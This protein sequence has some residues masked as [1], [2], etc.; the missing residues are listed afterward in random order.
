M[1]V[2]LILAGCGQHDGSETH[3]VVLTLLSLAQENIE[4]DSFAPEDNQRQVI[5]H[6]TE[7]KQ[8]GS[9]NILRESARLVRGKIKPMTKADPS[10]YDAI[11][12]PGGF[13]AVSNLCNWSEKGKDFSFHP[14]VGNFF[15]LA[16]SHKKPMGFICIAPMMIPQLYQNAKLTI[17]ND[18]SLAKQIQ[19]MG[20]THVNCAASDVVVDQNNKIVS[21][22]ANMVANS[23]AE[24]YEGIHKLVKALIKMT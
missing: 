13:G 21:T 3:E 7:E 4:W 5:N 14:D 10:I 19:E 12:I 1:K 16:L 24:V 20:S 6:Q 15:D 22:P 8:E 18:G 11:I 17:G 9:R 23:I 2:A